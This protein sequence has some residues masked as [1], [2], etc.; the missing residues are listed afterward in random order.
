[1][2]DPVPAKFATSA[3]TKPQTVNRRHDILVKTHVSASATTRVL[4]DVEIYGPK[5]HLVKQRTW[6]V[7]LS[8]GVTGTF[9]FSWHVKASRHTGRYTV[10]IGLFNPGWAGLLRWNNHA[11]TFKV[12]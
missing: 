8:A 10:K 6:T 7:T 12:R 9:K 3:L 1:M 11:A 5:G 4:V 2:A